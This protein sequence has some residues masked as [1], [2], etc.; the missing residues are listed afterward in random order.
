MGAA[1]KGVYVPNTELKHF[2]NGTLNGPDGKPFKTRAGGVMSL[3]ELIKM[4]YD[5]CYSRIND[6]IVESSKKEDT[7]M[8]IA[9]AAL[10]YADYLPYR[11]TDYIFD[12]NKFT[13]LDGKTGPYLLYST[14]RIRS[15]LNKATKEGIE[16]H[17]FNKI[18]NSSDRDVLLTLLQLPIMINRAYESKSLNDIAEYIYKLTSSYNKFY[19]ENKIILEENKDLRE[20]WL[21][22]S[23]V[24]Y[25]TN[26][27]L[28]NIMGI[29][30]PEKM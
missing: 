12:I 20:S 14:I 27:M 17:N 28:L 23:N 30:V 21:V 11:E 9:I 1:R 2:G 24:V 16:Y 3:E 10:K 18:N 5:S 7:A 8:K 6:D 13:D 19:S 29:D 15:L 25:N 26:M 4:I 22:L